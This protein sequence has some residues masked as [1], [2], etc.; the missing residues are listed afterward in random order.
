MWQHS[1]IDAGFA[2]ADT[3]AKAQKENMLN[4]LQAFEFRK[5]WAQWWPQLL[6]WFREE[7]LF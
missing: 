2:T 1:E 3:L 5:E 6:V 7:P 4:Q